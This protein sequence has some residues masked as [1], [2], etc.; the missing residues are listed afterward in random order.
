MRT[1]G[2]VLAALAAASTSACIIVADDDS[3]LTI[4]N[5]SDFVLAEVHL[6]EIDDPTWGPNLLPR[7]LYPGDDL[8]IV[9]IDCGVYD[10][11]VVELGGIECEL[12]GLELCFDDEDWVITNS[13][14]ARCAF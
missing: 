13:T 2:L 7:L 9:D 10:V 5:H 14:L 6:A 12:Y 3:S 11:L 8:V 4:H 1:S